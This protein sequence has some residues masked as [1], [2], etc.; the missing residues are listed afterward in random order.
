[1][2]GLH[3][4]EKVKVSYVD[5]RTYTL[6]V[7]VTATRPSNEFIGRVEA[8]FHS[9]EI[10]GGQVFDELIGQEKIF[11]NEDVVRRRS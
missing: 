2:T 10:T 6:D 4:G 5:D 8:I 11:K 9:G 1:M 7:E 3:L